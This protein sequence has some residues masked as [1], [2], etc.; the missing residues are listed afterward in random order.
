L[1]FDAILIGIEHEESVDSGN[2]EA[3]L[4]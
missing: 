1:Y 2:L 4:P 3:V